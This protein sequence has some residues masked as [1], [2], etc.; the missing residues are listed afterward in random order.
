MSRKP[1]AVAEP[2]AAQETRIEFVPLNLLRLSPHN[3]RQTTTN[4]S[5][6]S[7]A[8]SIKALGL[9]QNLVGYEG[10][11]SWFIAA[12]GRR[13]AALQLLAKRGALASD[14]LV[15]VN[16][17]TEAQAGAASLAENEQREQMNPADACEAFQGLTDEGWTI[18]RIADAFGV[19]PLMVERRLALA[20]AAP[21]LLEE[22]RAGKMTSAQLTALCA[23]DD[24]ARQIKVWRDAED[25]NSDPDDL[26]RSVL[27]QGEIDAE[28]DHRVKFIGG[29]KVYAAAGGE[30]RRDL[31]SAEGDGGFITDV[32]LLDRLV[33][34]KLE[35]E[36]EKVRAEGW[37][38]VEVWPK[39]DWTAMERLGHAPHSENNLP[40]AAK[41]ELAKLRKKIKD[42]EADQEQIEEKQ[43]DDDDSQ[44]DQWRKNDEEL[45]TLREQENDLEDSADS[46]ALDVRA[47]SG[48]VLYYN[49]GDM[50]I[51]RGRVRTADRKAVQQAARDEDAV[52]GGRE[53]EPAGRKTDEAPGSLISSLEAHRNL[54][55]QREVAKNPRVAKVLLAFWTV[56]TITEEHDAPNFLDLTITSGPGAR[57]STQFGDEAGTTARRTFLETECPM[58]FK[59]LPENPNALWQKLLKMDDAGLDAIIAV[60]VAKA[61]SL[62]AL[63]WEDDEKDN[64]LLLEALDLDMAKHF[65]PTAENYFRKLPAALVIAALKDA[66][67]LPDK[68]GLA[69]AEGMKKKDLVELAEELMKDSGWVPAEIRTAKAA[70]KKKA[71]KAK[72]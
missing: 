45:D 58:A 19:T 55:T 7:M 67:A 39:Q 49:H 46:Y 61:T 6:E 70:A 65:Q 47:K 50:E 62:I 42:L 37:G 12:G 25:Y 71:G 43:E 72:R 24:H 3:V 20:A 40:K 23:S 11:A 41:A 1:A 56:N 60:G 15:P 44:D 18:D 8:S 38:W 28:K 66:N 10:K 29:V 59:G 16:V 68:K 63:D 13:L 36:A 54:A 52:S 30:V 4:D 9:R 53:T 26:R 34:D 17:C 31:F 48:A 21:E 51:K 33:M 57:S 2:P 69:Q 22:V 32:V 27:Q 14:H 5:I 64:A 35:Q